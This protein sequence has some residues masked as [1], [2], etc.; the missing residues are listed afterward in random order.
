MTTATAQPPPVVAMLNR[1][2]GVGKSSCCQHLGGAFAR[3][4]KRVLLVDMDPQSSLTQGFF[5]PQAT[6]AMAR[7]ETLVALFDDACDPDPERVIR[8]TPFDGLFIAPGSNDLDS[9][10]VP[11][12]QETGEYQ[13][14][15]RTFLKEAK[16]RFDIVFID[17]PPNLHLASWNALLAADAVV[18]PLQGEDY[19]AQGITHVQRAIDLALTRANPDLRLA[20]YLLTMV[21]K[22]L[23]VHLAYEQQLRQLYGDDVFAGMVPLA[24][25]FK[26]A[27]A[28]RAPLSH[29]K[30][31]CAAAKV[32]AA[33]ADELAARLDRLRAEKPR[34]LY[35]GNRAGVGPEADELRRAS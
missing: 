4:G 18:I 33:I 7:H 16:G 34:F 28:A 30:P 24:K 26:E 6:E 29:Y 15:L 8:P 2:G 10:N 32:M 22:R 14:A 23:G 19:G 31:R 17:C 12:P 25:D 11:D 9:F 20:G 3:S 21:Q 27:V 13:N 35:L 1:K 5:G